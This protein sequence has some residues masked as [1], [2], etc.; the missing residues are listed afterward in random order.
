MNAGIPGKE[1]ICEVVFMDLKEVMQQRNFVVVGDTLN[2]EKYAH[3]I[4]KGLQE[5]GYQ[6]QAVGKELASINDVEG[7]IDVIDLCINPVKG[8]QLI[9]ENEKPFKCIVIQPG[10][11]SEPLKDYL[12]ENNLPYIEGCILVGLRLY[13][14]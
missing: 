7:D 5:K 9:K 14:K 12:N 10:A 13:A 11:E 2:E 4:K 6:A 1:T 8:L 3:K